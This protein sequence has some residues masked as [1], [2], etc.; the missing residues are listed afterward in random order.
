MGSEFTWFV[1]PVDGT[2]N[3][4][5]GFPLWGVS[6]GLR[7]GDAMIAGA[8]FLPALGE[9]YTVTLKGGA[10]LNGQRIHTSPVAKLA[11]A[12]ISHGDF[13]IGAN[14]TE[15]LEMN[16]RNISSRARMAGA[17]QRIKCMG[18]AVLEGAFVAA[19]RM[20]A[21]CMLAMKPWDVAVAG[22]LVTEAGGQVSRLDGSPYS[23]IGPDVLFSNGL[24][25]QD[26]LR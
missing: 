7:K 23:I 12:I 1:D 17:V 5:R 15:R 9:M 26:L 22:L 20:D 4:S 8:I 24:L 25:H 2:V 3:Y 21:Y 6:V 18:S 16:A 10:Y 19:G 14:E 13:N 11:D